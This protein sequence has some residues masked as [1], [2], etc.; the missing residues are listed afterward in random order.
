M[1][2]ESALLVLCAALS[3]LLPFALRGDRSLAT[4]LAYVVLSLLAILTSVLR[5]RRWA[6]VE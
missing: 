6:G 3:L 2:L 4:F 1:E 5:L